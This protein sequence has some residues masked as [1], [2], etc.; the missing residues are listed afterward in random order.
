MSTS[1]IISNTRPISALFKKRY[2]E[3]C[4]HLFD[5]TNA[6]SHKVMCISN[7]SMTERTLIQTYT[8][9]SFSPVYVI[10]T[11]DSKLVRGKIAHPTF[12]VCQLNLR[13]SWLQ[14]SSYFIT[15]IDNTNDN[16]LVPLKVCCFVI[17]C[18]RV[19][20]AL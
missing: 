20:S 13:D 4:L 16:I 11:L 2:P 6:F 7:P 1:L 19:A 8:K 15:K 10:F 18:T 9:V 17:R 5:K 14:Y 3:G 12:V